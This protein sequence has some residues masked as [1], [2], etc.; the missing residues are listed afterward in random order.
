ME[1]WIK[2][3]LTTV[4][5]KKTLKSAAEIVLNLDELS[6]FQAAFKA[7]MSLWNKKPLRV[8]GGRMSESMLAILCNIIKGENIIK[9][10][11]AKEREEMGD[12]SNPLAVTGP[13]TSGGAGASPA[14]PMVPSRPSE[15]DVDEAHL[16]QVHVYCDDNEVHEK[17]CQCLLNTHACI[18]HVHFSMCIHA[19]IK[20]TSFATTKIF[21]PF[22][23]N[24]IPQ[25]LFRNQV[26]I[27]R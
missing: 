5:L 24:R 13:S 15:P 1:I 20:K 18:V 16:Q 17:T 19:Y 22:V 8:Y 14:V 23:W 27:T 26:D 21:S 11:L 9:E 2:Q 12:V 25:S 3:V 10:R 6:C 4:T 7:V